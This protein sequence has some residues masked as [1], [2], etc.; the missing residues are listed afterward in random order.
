MKTKDYIKTPQF[1]AKVHRL[2]AEMAHHY[3]D[4][5]PITFCF[6]EMKPPRAH[7]CKR[8]MLC[9]EFVLEVGRGN[10]LT[11]WADD[12]GNITEKP[13]QATVIE[14]GWEYCRPDREEVHRLA[15]TA[16][17]NA[18]RFVRK[19]GVPFGVKIYTNTP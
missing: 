3:D 2:T 19:L 1:A 15:A 8:K 7:P 6:I 14:Q 12:N 17:G 10:F 4:Q 11:T 18:R 13:E 5:A 16:M 9:M